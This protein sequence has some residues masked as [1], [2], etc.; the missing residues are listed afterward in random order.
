MVNLVA[1]RAAADA[2]EGQVIRGSQVQVVEPFA[3]E[4]QEGLFD[5]EARGGGSD[6]FA[7]AAAPS[8]CCQFG[9]LRAVV[10][11]VVTMPQPTDDD[12][13]IS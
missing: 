3:V 12:A 9:D 11:H 8:R 4:I 1:A 6:G 10:L 2:H 7:H 13:D 5:L